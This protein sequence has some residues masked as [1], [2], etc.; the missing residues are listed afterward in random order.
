MSRQ[1]TTTHAPVAGAFTM[2]GTPQCTCGYRHKSRFGSKARDKLR[3]H[4][5]KHNPPAG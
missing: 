2:A 4:L 5:A 3:K 1:R